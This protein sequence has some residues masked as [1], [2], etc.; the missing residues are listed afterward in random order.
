MW[1]VEPARHWHNKNTF[2]K[3]TLFNVQ[4]CQIH[5]MEEHTPAN[6]N[7]FFLLEWKKY[8]NWSV[9]WFE[10]LMFEYGLS[11]QRA[12]LCQKLHFI[13]QCAISWQKLYFNCQRAICFPLQY[14]MSKG[15]KS[16]FKKTWKTAVNNTGSL[17]TCYLQNC[18]VVL[19]QLSLT[20]YYLSW[21]Q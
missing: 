19:N 8:L 16:S 18:C 4:F 17:F 2:V 14:F 12:I 10:M 15:D 20:L 3:M 21:F 13:F 6:L 7:I 5:R 11:H 9:Y 1:K